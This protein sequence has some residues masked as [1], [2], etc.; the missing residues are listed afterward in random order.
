MEEFLIIDNNNNIFNKLYL[1]LFLLLKFE[2]SMDII[3]KF[4]KENIE[5]SIKETM[6]KEET[7]IKKVV[8]TVMEEVIDEVEKGEVIKKEVV[9]K[10]ECKK[11]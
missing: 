10:K 1:K 9:D 6:M 8:E 11:I 7:E 3:L 4:K 5:N 2:E